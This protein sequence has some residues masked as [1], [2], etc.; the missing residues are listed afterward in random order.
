M[1]IA[2]VT[3]AHAGWCTKVSYGY[4]NLPQGSWINGRDT[5]NGELAE[6]SF[7]FDA[8]E[9]G[10]SRC[11]WIHKDICR[12]HGDET[13]VAATQNIAQVCVDD[14]IE[15]PVNIYNAMGLVDLSAF[16]WHPLEVF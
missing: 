15:I 8:Y 6:C 10:R 7:K 5:R 11:M 4:K 13:R 12:F 2:K 1:G 3:Q 16:Q 9:K 14:R